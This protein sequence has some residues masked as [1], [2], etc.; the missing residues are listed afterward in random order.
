MKMRAF[1]MLFT[2]VSLLTL[3]ACSPGSSTESSSTEE[4]S[5]STETKKSTETTESTKSSETTES[6]ATATSMP[7]QFSLMIEAAQSQIPT[8]MEQ[9]GDEYSDISITEGEN[10]TIVYTYTTAVDPGYAVDM[11]ALKPVLAKG[12]KPVINQAKLI[13]DDVKIQVI[14]LRP[15]K[16]EIGNVIITQEDT[17]NIDSETPEQ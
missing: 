4:T 9:M 3:T 7:D 5:V 17:N 11:E 16:T 15:D 1:T 12:L 14:Y 6:S 8:L 10:H 2:C 13:A